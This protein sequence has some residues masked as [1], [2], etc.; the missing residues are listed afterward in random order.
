VND[1]STSFVFK[2]ERAALRERGER[3]AGTR[4]GMDHA[5]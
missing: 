3:S 4:N 5:F 2:K 1:K